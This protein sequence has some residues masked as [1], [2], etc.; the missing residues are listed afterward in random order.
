MDEEPVIVK[1]I[2]PPQVIGR[3]RPR[4]A[5]CNLRLLKRMEPGNCIWEV[6]KRK[7]NSIRVTANRYKVKIKVR[8]LPSGNYGIW[9]L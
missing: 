1:G 9:K 2:T 7:M 3:G 4:G 6:S 5:G 8:L